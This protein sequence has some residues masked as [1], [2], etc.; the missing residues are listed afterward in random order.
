M[1]LSDAIALGRMILRPLG[2]TFNDG[3]GGGCALGMAYMAAGLDPYKELFSA[4]QCEPGWKWIENTLLVLPC[5]C[6]GYN[7]LYALS[8]IVHLFDI[9][10]MH[11]G[12]WT[13]DQLI[14]WVS[15][16][17]AAPEVRSKLIAQALYPDLKCGAEFEA[18]IARQVELY[19][20]LVREL[21]IKLE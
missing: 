2:G 17:L 20:R 21:N 9:H 6:T 3:K 10:V 13:L 8:T 18:H 16:A 19:T 5:G 12:D 7:K 11:L 14:D 15:G 4:M 1:R